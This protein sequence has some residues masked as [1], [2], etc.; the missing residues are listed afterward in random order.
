MYKITR[1]VALNDAA[2]EMDILAPQVAKKCEP[3]QFVIVRVDE[4]GERIPLTI[5]DY[6]PEKGTITLVVQAV[7]FSTKQLDKLGEGDYIAD[8]VGPLGVPTKLNGNHKRVV[9]VAGGIGSAPVYPQLKKL[10]EMGVSVDVIIG[11]REKQYVLWAEKFAKFCDHVYIATDNG[12]VG[13]KGFVTTVL[14]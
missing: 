3:G 6:D 5:G 8:F 13:T 2:F 11:G 1:K 9:G 7:G 12:E 14:Q 10:A 4:E